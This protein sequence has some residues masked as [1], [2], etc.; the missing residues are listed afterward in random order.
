[1]RMCVRGGISRGWPRRRRR[2]RYMSTEEFHVFY[3]STSPSPLYL[4]QNAPFTT[5][6]QPT[7]RATNTHTRTI[8]LTWHTYSVTPSRRARKNGLDKVKNLRPA[9]V[10]PHHAANAT[11]ACREIV[12]A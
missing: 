8:H 2:D 6:Y 9:R 4:K 10:P 1:M 3:F 5:M 12:P 11:W 7:E